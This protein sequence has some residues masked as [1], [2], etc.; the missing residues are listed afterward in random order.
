MDNKTKASF[1]VL[2][3]YDHEFSNLKQ[4]KLFEKTYKIYLLR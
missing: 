4:D 1:E 3:S 2:V